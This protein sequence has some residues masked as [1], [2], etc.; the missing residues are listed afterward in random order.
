MKNLL[1]QQMLLQGQKP[2]TYKVVK[3]LWKGLDSKRKV[4]IV[5]KKV[6]KKKN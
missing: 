1:N 6:T 2:K 3:I 5:Q 4:Q